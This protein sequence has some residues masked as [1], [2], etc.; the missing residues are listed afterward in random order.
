MLVVPLQNL[1]PVDAGSH[2]VLADIAPVE[3]P[4]GQFVK[5]LPDDRIEEQRADLRYLCDLLERDTLGAALGTS[6]SWHSASISTD[7]TNLQARLHACR[8]VPPSK[9]A[10]QEIP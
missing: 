6:R 9:R 10:T 3:D 2:S 8:A 5:I 4:T 7:S 1:F